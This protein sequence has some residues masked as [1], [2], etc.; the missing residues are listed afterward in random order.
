MSPLFCLYGH[1]E[2]YIIFEPLH[3][4][5]YDM[6]LGFLTYSHFWEADCCLCEPRRSRRQC[7][8]G[9]IVAN[10]TQIRVYELQRA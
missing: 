5:N 2:Q 4:S 7:L 3:E 9:H 1:V 8:K 6:N 10:S